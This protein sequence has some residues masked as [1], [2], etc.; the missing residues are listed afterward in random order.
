[1]SRKDK[2]KAEER[3]SVACLLGDHA[4]PFHIAGIYDPVPLARTSCIDYK[5]S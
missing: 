3:Q 1:M 5:G 4:A 2:S